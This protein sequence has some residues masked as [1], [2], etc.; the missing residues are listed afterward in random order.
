[1]KT[2]ENRIREQRKAKGMTQVDL[3]RALQIA[4]SSDNF[5]R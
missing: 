2:S 5:F 4:A 3:A 1:M